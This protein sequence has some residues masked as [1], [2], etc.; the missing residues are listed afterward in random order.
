MFNSLLEII[1]DNTV[2]EILIEQFSIN[3]NIY[4]LDIK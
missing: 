4:L 3:T 1:I 2:I